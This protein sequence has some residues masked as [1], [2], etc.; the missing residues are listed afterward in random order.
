MAPEVWRDHAEMLD[1]KNSR[2]W[3]RMDIHCKMKGCS[4]V[5]RIDGVSASMGVG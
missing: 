5:T 3:A 1:D 4:D 2:L